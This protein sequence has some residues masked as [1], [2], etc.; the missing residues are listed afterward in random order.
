MANQNT[1]KGL[2]IALW[3]AQSLLAVVYVMAGS[4]K[5]FQPIAELAKMLPWVT[6]IPTGL[7]RFIGVSELLGGVGLLL[8]ALLRIIPALTPVAAVGLTIIQVL[9]MFFH[10][11][12]GE[13]SVI[14]VNLLF[15]V[16]AVFIAWGRFQR[17]PIYAK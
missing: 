7:V 6:D 10:L 4:N 3:V 17:A 13:T 5:L 12:K 11:S 14:G 2:N 8:P 16:I 15:M 9:A 1:S